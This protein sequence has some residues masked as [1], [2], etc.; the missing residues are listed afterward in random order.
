M[1]APMWVEPLEVS[2]ILKTEAA[3]IAKEEQA[4]KAFQE[5]AAILRQREL[6]AAARRENIER[7]LQAR[8]GSM[9]RAAQDHVSKV[10]D[11]FI[12]D[13]KASG[14]RRGDGIFGPAA[15]LFP[16]FVRS[17][18][19]MIR[20]RWELESKSYTVEDFGDADWKSRKLEAVV[21]RTELKLQNKPLGR[22]N[23]VCVLFGVIIDAEFLYLR[24]TIETPC[25]GASDD[26]KRWQIG[27]KFNSRWRAPTN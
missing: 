27:S 24:D 18:K 9:A 2:A 7:D 6:D 23:T 15:E 26:V 11:T 21:V 17:Y 19:Q 5:E 12:N 8:N 22:R 20:D 3:Q 13:V 14:D 16:T 4:R 1:L 25:N 10:I